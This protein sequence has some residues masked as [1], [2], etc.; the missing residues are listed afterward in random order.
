VIEFLYRLNILRAIRIY[1]P[2]LRKED[3]LKQE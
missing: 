2:G 3:A 1:D